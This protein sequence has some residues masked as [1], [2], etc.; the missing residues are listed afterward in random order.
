VSSV[1]L[2][3]KESVHNLGEAGDVVSVKPGYARNYLLPQGKAIPATESRVAELE[4][5]KRILAEKVAKDLKDLRSRKQALE[6]LSLQISARAG[7]GGRLFG[8]VTA[9]QISDALAQAG[10]EV[11]RRRIDVREAIKEIGKHSVPVKLHREVVA[12]ITV[13]VIAQTAPEEAEEQLEGGPDEPRE[14]RRG[15]RR[16]RDEEESE[17]AEASEERADSDED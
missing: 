5:H 8:S 9:A 6:G 4:H 3:L 13:D 12:K 2:I 1:K 14:R 7:E 10:H 17:A 15:R 16:D 11:D